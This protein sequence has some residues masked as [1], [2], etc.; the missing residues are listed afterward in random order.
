MNC[1]VYSSCLLLQGIGD[2]HALKIFEVRLR[3][4]AQREID[5]LKTLEHEN[6]VA[7]MGQETDVSFDLL[8]FSGI[9]P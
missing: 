3:G 1:F 4:V 8:N 2:V 7:F 9:E 5:A 6:I